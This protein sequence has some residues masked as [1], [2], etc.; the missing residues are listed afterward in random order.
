MEKSIPHYRLLEIQAQMAT[1]NSMRLTHSAKIGI[2]SLGMRNADALEVVQGLTR[3]NFYKSMTTKADHRVWQ[4]V[5]HGEWRG[6]GLYVKFQRDMDG[7]FFTISF[8]SLG[9]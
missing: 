9:D 2:R 5:Y 6:L 3:R 4:D 8:K 7:Y 1:V